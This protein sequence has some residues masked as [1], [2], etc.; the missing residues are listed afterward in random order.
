MY[1]NQVFFLYNKLV[2]LA[3]KVFFGEKPK[4]SIRAMRSPSFD[5]GRNI[6]NL[7]LGNYLKASTF[8]GI[9]VLTGV[10]KILCMSYMFRV[11]IDRNVMC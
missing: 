8:Y 3:V 6:N 1:P 2:A 4:Q 9:D 11:V 5:T 7:E 10:R